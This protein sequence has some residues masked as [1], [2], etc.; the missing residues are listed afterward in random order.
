M[1]YDRYT[2]LLLLDRPLET[3]GSRLTEL[4]QWPSQHANHARGCYYFRSSAT[5][6]YSSESQSQPEPAQT[7]QVFLWAEGDTRARP[8]KHSTSE[9]MLRR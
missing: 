7:C 9:A 4:R 5:S 1:S 6:V 2:V 8:G 3:A